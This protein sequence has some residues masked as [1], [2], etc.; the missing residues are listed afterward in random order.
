MNKPDKI[1]VG[2]IIG[3]H[4]IKGEVKLKSFTEVPE[5]V[6][7]Y[8][9][10]EDKSGKKYDLKVVGHSKEVLRAKVKGVDDRN[11]AE[12]LIGTELWVD[13]NV[14]PELEDNNEFYHID[15][16]GLAVKFE[17]KEIGKVAGVYNFGA[18][19][20]IEVK[21]TST[22]KTEMFPFTNA[23]FPEVNIKDGYIIITTDM[24]K[25]KEEESKDES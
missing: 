2:A 21:L 5:A 11:V 25:F 18:G 4:G 16:I 8:G 12:T 24:L 20:I 1:C 19:D 6:G 7:K 14:L 13:R 17:N 15:L 22:G 10:L 23:Y 9:T 3:V